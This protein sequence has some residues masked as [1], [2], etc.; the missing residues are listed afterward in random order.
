M[1]LE[2]FKWIWWMEYGHRS[3]GR[4]IGAA[5]FIPAAGFWATGRINGALKRRVVAFGALIAAQGLMGWYMVKSGLEDR[6]HGENDVPRVRSTIGVLTITYPN[7]AI[8][9][10]AATR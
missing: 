10:C 5:F 6:F 9:N 3:W 1:S 7:I 2:E 4:L 8:E